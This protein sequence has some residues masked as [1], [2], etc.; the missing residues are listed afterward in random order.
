MLAKLAFILFVAVLLSE[1]VVT[2]S[3]NPYMGELSGRLQQMPRR[4]G[5]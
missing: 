1:F 5:K 2:G 4:A 3:V